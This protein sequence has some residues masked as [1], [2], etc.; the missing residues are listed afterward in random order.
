MQTPHY[1]ED[2][3]HDYKENAQAQLCQ[4]TR[5]LRD[6]GD[7]LAGLAFSKEPHL[8]GGLQGELEDPMNLYIRHA[9]EGRA[10]SPESCRKHFTLRTNRRIVACWL[11]ILACAPSGPGSAKGTPRS[12]LAGPASDVPPMQR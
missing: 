12:W 2:N 5:Y 1:N 10:Y 9:G 11:R 4:R 3:R 6:S 8:V 7:S